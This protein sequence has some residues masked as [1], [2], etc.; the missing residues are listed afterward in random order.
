MI[1]GTFGIFGI[2]RIYGIYGIFQIIVFE[3]FGIFGTYGIFGTFLISSTQKS[4]AHIIGPLSSIRRI[5]AYNPNSFVTFSLSTYVGER[6]YYLTS[7]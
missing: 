1:N 2:F 4:R 5:Q 3:T 6:S 7:L